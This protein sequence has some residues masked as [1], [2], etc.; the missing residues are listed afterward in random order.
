VYEAETQA[1][2]YTLPQWVFDAA[3]PPDRLMTWFVQV[4]QRTADGLLL[5]MSAPSEERVFY[6]R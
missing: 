6:W 4:R 1:A 3:A 2:E 5:E